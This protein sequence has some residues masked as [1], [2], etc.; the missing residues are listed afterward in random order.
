MMLECLHV[1]GMCLC[2]GNGVDEGEM[3][4][5]TQETEPDPADWVSIRELRLGRDLTM[6]LV[7]LGVLCKY[8]MK[9]ENLSL[10]QDE[11]LSI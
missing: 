5:Q 6:T 9:F 2:L 3:R 1:M 10:P 4:I 11:H 8:S 7:I